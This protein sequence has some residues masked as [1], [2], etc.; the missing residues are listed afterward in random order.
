MAIGEHG[1]YA[2]QQ[3]LELVAN[4]RVVEA[5]GRATLAVLDLHDITATGHDVHSVEYIHVW[6]A[7]R[8]TRQVLIQ[9][10]RSALGRARRGSGW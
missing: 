1:V 3:Q 8:T 10:M 4:Q 5:A 2:A 9:E 6:Q 7:I